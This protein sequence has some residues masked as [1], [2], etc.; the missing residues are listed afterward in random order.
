[1]EQFKKYCQTLNPSQ[2]IALITDLQEAATA[3]Q[4]VA[5][6][7]KVLGIKLHEDYSLSAQEAD[8]LVEVALSYIQSYTHQDEQ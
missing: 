7:L 1:M 8:Q 3:N 4:K 5:N 6:R 2:L